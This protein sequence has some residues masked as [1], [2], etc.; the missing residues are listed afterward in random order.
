MVLSL[1]DNC[2]VAD[3]VVDPEFVKGTILVHSCAVEVEILII[4][5]ASVWSNEAKARSLKIHDHSG[6]APLC[7][8]VFFSS[9]PA[10]A[11]PVATI[12]TSGPAWWG[13]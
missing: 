1:I 6:C 3:L 8:V 7:Q 13:A 12:I 11:S 5:L 10:A 2:L 4:D 9:R